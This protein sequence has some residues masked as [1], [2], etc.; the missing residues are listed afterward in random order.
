MSDCAAE[1]Y[2]EAITRFEAVVRKGTP[3]SDSWAN[4]SDEASVTV[5]TGIL[6]LPTI[7]REATRAGVELYYVE[8]ESAQA[9]ENIRASLQYRGQV[10]L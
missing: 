3:L 1:R 4:I 5:G 6:D 9:P 10:E 2:R 7:L 8:D